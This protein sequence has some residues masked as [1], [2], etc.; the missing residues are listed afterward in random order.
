MLSPDQIKQ[1]LKAFGIG[2]SVLIAGILVVSGFVIYKNYLETTNLKLQIA[3][4][5]IDLTK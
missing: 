2:G 3:Q 5:K 1:V 4:R